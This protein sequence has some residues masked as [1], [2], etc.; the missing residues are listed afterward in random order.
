MR[1]CFKL[2]GL[3]LYGAPVDAAPHSDLLVPMA[4]SS[5]VS[6]DYEDLLT[7][8]K[9]LCYL[10][11]VVE[12]G[13]LETVHLKSCGEFVLIVMK[14]TMSF[15]IRSIRKQPPEVKFEL[16]PGDSNFIFPICLR[17]AESKV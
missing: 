3:T 12:L 6:L 8:Y 2:A 16:F 17:Q 10:V 7:A 14:N 4:W 15:Q 5:F 13:G 1:V 11:L 9:W